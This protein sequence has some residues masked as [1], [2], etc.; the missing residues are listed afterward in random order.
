MIIRQL[1]VFLEDKSGRLTELTK[2]LAENDVN[3]SALSIADAADYGIIRMVVGR[4]DL[5]VKVL[6]EHGFSVNTTEVACLIVPNKPGGLYKAL[7]I[8]TDNKVDIDYMYAFDS[9]SRATVVIRTA[10]I[11]EVIKIL[12]DHKL[13][14][15]KAS[16]VYQV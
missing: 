9:G 13:E 14:L 15:L 4:P 3:I 6:K 12:Q 5:A 2:I 7:Q 10:N 16:Q 8:L 1:S 11:P